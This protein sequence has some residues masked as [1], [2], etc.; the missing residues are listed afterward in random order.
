MI[1]QHKGDKAARILSSFSYLKLHTLT[2]CGFYTAP[3]SFKKRDCHDFSVGVWES[4]YRHGRDL[5]ITLIGS[6]SFKSP[7]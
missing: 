6:L 5:S 2:L 4:F 3:L 7:F 1:G